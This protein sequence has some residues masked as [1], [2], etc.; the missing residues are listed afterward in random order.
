MSSAENEGRHARPDRA[1][2]ALAASC[3]LA[4]TFAGRD[5]AADEGRLVL[6]T[7]DPALASA[8]SVAVSPRGLSVVELSDALLRASDVDDARRAVSVHDAIAVV[9]LCDDVAG[10]HALCFCDRDGHL[11][12]RPISVGSPLAPPDA[13][14]L[15]L[16]VKVLL[17]PP[18][19]P[20]AAP[21][22]VVARAA[23]PA[24]SMDGPR[25]VVVTAD[26]PSLAVELRGGARVPDGLRD[27]SVL[28]FGLDGVFAPDALGRQLGVGVGLSAGPAFEGNYRLQVDD[29][30]FGLLA[31]GQRRVGPLV[32]QLDLGPTAHLVSAA[33]GPTQHRTQLSIDALVGAVWTFGRFTAG[34]RL[35][36]VY[37]PLADV[38]AVPVS[39]G[40]MLPL[41]L[42]P[43]NGEALLTFGATFLGP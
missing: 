33:S 40:F 10:A 29:L 15:A 8:L 18:P 25:S 5:A 23:R 13:A 7:H 31:R 2:L 34:A 36:V 21:A 42:P 20:A 39:V 11:T 37:V 12:V 17:G 14:A 19:P 4:A 6:G 26:V 16:S 32:L 28:R 22:P 3:A 9:W 27:R 41:S 43:W 35:G 1:R 38:D 30:A 24:P